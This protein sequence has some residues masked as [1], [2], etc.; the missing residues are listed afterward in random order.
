M[1]E[2]ENVPDIGSILNRV[3]SDP[4]ML[5]KAMD[6]AER[7][8]ASDAL[9]GILPDENDCG[10]DTDFETAQ[11]QNGKFDRHRRLLEALLPYL[12]EARREKADMLLKMIR[13]LELADGMGA[14]GLFGRN[15]RV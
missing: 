11:A 15:G 7:L 10:K 2:Q 3:L 6:T 9:E 5:K 13:L 14:L 12:G 1:A 4:D 8:K